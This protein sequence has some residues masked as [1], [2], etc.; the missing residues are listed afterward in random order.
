MRDKKFYFIFIFIKIFS[1]F[2][3][4]RKWGKKLKLK[5]KKKSFCHI[6]FL[7]FY[8]SYESKIC[9]S[10][11]IVYTPYGVQHVHSYMHGYSMYIR[12]HIRICTDH[13]EKINGRLDFATG[14]GRRRRR[15]R[16]RSIVAHPY[17]HNNVFIS[18]L[19]TATRWTVRLD[20]DVIHI[21]HLFLSCTYISWSTE[22]LELYYIFCL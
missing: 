2:K 4:R 21:S 6:F 22:V 15:R 11:C 13:K 7:S 14:S 9:T 10:V 5:K 18:P 8:I 3:K 12:I 17:I 1:L 16:R 20:C 19:H